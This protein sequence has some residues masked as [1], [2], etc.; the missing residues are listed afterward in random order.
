MKDWKLEL[1]MI[2]IGEEN[3]EDMVIQRDFAILEHEQKATCAK[4]HTAKIFFVFI[5][6]IFYIV[7]HL[8]YSLC[9]P[10]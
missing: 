8:Q 3:G 2:Q 4:T 9:M 7:I 1:K 10:S 5:Y 6:F